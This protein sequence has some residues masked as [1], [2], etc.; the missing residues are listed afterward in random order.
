MVAW[1]SSTQLERL[2]MRHDWSAKLL[3]RRV[4]PSTLGGVLDGRRRRTHGAAG[5]SAERRPVEG[6]AWTSRSGRI[7]V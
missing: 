4:D 2:D 5:G 7:E 3:V 1:T 6:G